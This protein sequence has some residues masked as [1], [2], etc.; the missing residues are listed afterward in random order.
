V[1]VRFFSAPNGARIA[2]TAVGCGPPLVLVPPLMSHLEA[3]WQ[4]DGHRRFCS[5]LAEQHTVVMYDRWGCGL[6]DRDREDMSHAADVDVLAGLIAHLRLRRVSL[7]GPSQGGPVAME[8]ADRCPQAVANL[9]LFGMS[10]VSRAGGPTWMALRELM[11][12]DWSVAAP[13]VAA[14]LCAGADQ[15]EQATF[16]RLLQAGATAEMAVALLAAGQGRDVTELAARVRVPTLVACRSGDR[17]TPAESARLLAAHIPGSEFALLDGN[18]HVHYLGDVDSFADVVLAFL[19]R[20]RRPADPA[21][22]PAGPAGA[23]TGRESE[24]L[25]LVAGGFTNAAIAERLV[26]SVRTVERHTLNIYT[27]LGVRGRAEAVAVGY[28]HAGAST[29][30]A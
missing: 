20:G 2:Y 13:A 21:V 25:E 6:S 19:R 27:K 29:G 16:A 30:P 18:A 15:E 11:L 14:V 3:M 1:E 9:V 12:A 7:Y 4:I 26:L 5:R 8:Y 10:L 17:L 23:L 22:V 28:R 24:I